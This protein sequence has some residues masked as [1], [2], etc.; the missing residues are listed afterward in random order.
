MKF[1]Y[2]LE[3][4]NQKNFIRS[5][6][7][8][9]PSEQYGERMWQFTDCNFAHKKTTNVSDHIEIKHLRSEFLF[10]NQLFKETHET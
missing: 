7:M 9:V 1:I 10:N 8:M 4:E 2:L 5:K 3:I 6:M